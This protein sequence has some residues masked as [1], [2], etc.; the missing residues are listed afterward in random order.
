MEN[1]N[2]TGRVGLLTPSKSI[3]ERNLKQVKPRDV[4]KP[5]PIQED[6]LFRGTAAAV[7][8]VS[9]EVRSVSGRNSGRP[10]QTL[11]CFY[12]LLFLINLQMEETLSR[13]KCCHANQLS[14]HV[15]QAVNGFTG[16]PR[17]LPGFRIWMWQEV[18]PDWFVPQ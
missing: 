4:S 8:F 6:A 13:A 16:N 11:V 5:P 10:E 1:Q 3:I 14:M 2:R 12:C 15:C 17:N 9:P 18:P 7:M